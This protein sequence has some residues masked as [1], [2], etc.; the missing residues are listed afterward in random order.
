[1]PVC[2]AIATQLATVRNASPI[3]I[4]GVGHSSTTIQTWQPRISACTPALGATGGLFGTEIRRYS[5]LS[6]I[7]WWSRRSLR[8]A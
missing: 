5:A 8:P 4:E 7:V 3:A 2:R 6:G 1:M